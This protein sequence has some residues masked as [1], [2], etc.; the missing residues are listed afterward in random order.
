MK[1]TKFIV[2]SSGKG[3]VGKTT[4]AINLGTALSMQGRD[5]IV[6]DGNL[7]TPD[8]GLY[9]GAPKVPVSLHDVLQNQ[10]SIF[11]AVYKHPSGL[12]VIPAAISL[13]ALKGLELR[14]LK[15]VFQELKGESE[16]VII[17]SAAGLGAD[18]Q[19][20]FKLADEA[21][22]VTNPEIAAV[23]NALKTARLA[24]N[25]GAT[26]IGI[27]LNK[28]R[29]D[30]YEMSEKEIEE[31]LEIPIIAKI[32]ESRKIR[33]AYQERQPIVYAYPHSSASKAF[34]Q[35]A[36]KISFEVRPKS[37]KSFWKAFLEWLGF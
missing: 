20:V 18:V 4:T 32:P 22:I 33:K 1:H 3:G 7:T 23:T 12:K 6:M 36:S 31:I 15:K 19:K 25:Y 17:D 5:V 24:E 11:E 30:R 21:L 29:K 8:L 2:I 28:L 27:V 9:L 10:K 13:N 26:V 35:L 34:K 16:L 37:K 14:K